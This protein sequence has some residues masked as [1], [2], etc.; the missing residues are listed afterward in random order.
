M[1]K[2]ARS[3]S[4]KTNNQRLKKDVFGPVETARTNRLSAKLLELAAQPKPIR[5]V[6]ME[7]AAVEEPVEEVKET[8][9]EVDSSAKATGKKLADGK[10]RIEKR[11]KSKIVF[12]KFG[13]RKSLKSLKKKK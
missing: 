3:S 1:A 4:L 6:E 11:R 8:A 2:S 10:K 12:S 5:E 13:D 7:E 9:M